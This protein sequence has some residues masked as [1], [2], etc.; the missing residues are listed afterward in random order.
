MS[1]TNVCVDTYDKDNLSLVPIVQNVIVV[2]HQQP[3]P[4]HFLMM[5]HSEQEQQQNLSLLSLGSLV[6]NY[7]VCCSN[8]KCP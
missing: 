2:A 5:H 3:E 8:F 4:N 6:S 7:L 1:Q